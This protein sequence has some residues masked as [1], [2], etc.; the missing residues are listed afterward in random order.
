[1]IDELDKKLITE[2]QKDS[3]RSYVDL[4]GRLAV[5]EGTVRK[6][7]IRLLDKDIIKIVAI[8]NLRNLGYRFVS[9]MG[10]QVSMPDLRQVVTNLAQKQ[11]V[12]FVT[13]VTGTYDLIVIIITRSIEEYIRFCESELRTIPG[14]L[15]TE[16]FIILDIAKGSV[17]LLD[18]TGL[19]H[20]L[21][22]TSQVNPKIG[23]QVSN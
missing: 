23:N 18:T 7:L 21:D 20:N 1:M 13:I 3:W 17:N 14:I 5:H 22:T 15:R 11:H 2:L 9:I 10:V 6:R 4:G 12:C 16:G 8:P 19:I